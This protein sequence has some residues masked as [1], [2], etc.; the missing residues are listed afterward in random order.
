MEPSKGSYLLGVR[1]GGARASANMHI[2]QWR[3]TYFEELPK[4]GFRLLMTG[5]RRSHSVEVLQAVAS[6]MSKKGYTRPLKL[7]GVR[8]VFTPQRPLLKSQNAFTSRV[9]SKRKRSATQ[10]RAWEQRP[11]RGNTGMSYE[12]NPGDPRGDLSRRMGKFLWCRLGKRSGFW[13]LPM[14]IFAVMLCHVR[15]VPLARVRRVGT[16]FAQMGQESP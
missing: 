14:R 7:T 9:G 8:R 1:G 13:G 5:L 11:G 3:R 16:L 4:D 6:P 15:N 10:Q 2:L 12:E